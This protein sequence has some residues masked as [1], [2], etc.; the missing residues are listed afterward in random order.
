[1]D[2]EVTN[3]CTIKW[4]IIALDGTHWMSEYRTLIIFA[5]R[6]RYGMYNH[7]TANTVQNYKLRVTKI[8]NS[9]KISSPK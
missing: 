8:A 5:A 3:T 9:I 2:I 6:Y 7:V 1:M 4:L